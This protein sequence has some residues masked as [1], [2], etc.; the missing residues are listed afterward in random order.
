MD[1]LELIPFGREN[2]ISRARL[3]SLTGL[4]DRA[5]REKIAQLRRHHVIINDQS[6]RGYYRTDNIDEIQAFVRQ[7]EARLRSIGWSL[8]AARQ[9]LRT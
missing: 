5:L 3:C 4:N 6:G 2:A 1:L 7:E 8:K 9:K